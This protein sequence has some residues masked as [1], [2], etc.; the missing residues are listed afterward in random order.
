[1]D[2]TLCWRMTLMIDGIVEV[3]ARGC[4]RVG[5][6]SDSHGPVDS[7]I[8]D[9]ISNCDFLIHAGDLGGS[10]ALNDLLQIA[11]ATAARGN[12]DTA[13][14]RSAK[15]ECQSNCYLLTASATNTPCE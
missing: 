9:A 4:R 13:Y 8:I 1:M 14:R 3:D 7:R 6:V 5:L 10:A 12:N 11:R 15:E 2:L